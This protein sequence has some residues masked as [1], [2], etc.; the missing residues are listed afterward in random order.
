[1]Y[2]SFLEQEFHPGKGKQMKKNL[3]HMFLSA[4]IKV[5]PCDLQKEF[6]VCHGVAVRAIAKAKVLKLTQEKID[7][8]TS[9]EL[10]KLWHSKSNKE[11]KKTRISLSST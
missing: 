2:S 10:H 5:R 8:L 9:S 4:A 11:L 6:K 1:M 3:L 7:S